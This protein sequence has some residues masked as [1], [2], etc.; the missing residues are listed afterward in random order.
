MS[1]LRRGTNLAAILIA[2]VAFPL[3]WFMLGQ[4][5]IGIYGAVVSGLL[6]GVG[7]GFFTEYFTS[8]SYKPTK[9]LAETSKTGSATIIIGGLSLGMKSTFVPVVIV[10]A[11]VLVSYFI[12]GGANDPGLGSTA[13]Q[14]PP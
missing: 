8:D 10:G 14:F 9:D 4:D 7:I 11:S 12:S 6:A 3:V 1:A 2:I 5:Y 13:S